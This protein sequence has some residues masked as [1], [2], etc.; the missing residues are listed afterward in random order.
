MLLFINEKLL[1]TMI[2]LFYN[3]SFE[4][5]IRIIVFD[6]FFMRRVIGGTAVDFIIIVDAVF[7]VLHIWSI[8]SDFIAIS[9]YLCLILANICGSFFSNRIYFLIDLCIMV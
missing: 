5:G 8:V 7:V 9:I 3:F 2:Q 4:D 6:Y 1:L